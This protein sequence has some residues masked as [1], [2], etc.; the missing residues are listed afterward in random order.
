MVVAVSHTTREKR[1]KETDAVNYHFV[2]PGVFQRMI[3]EDAFLE[4][5]KV[6]DHLYGTSKVA[7]ERD[8]GVG[9]DV[10]LEIDWQGARQV[11]AALPQAVSIFILPP[12]LASLRSRLR[13]RGQ[14]DN[15]VIETR[16]AAARGEISHC[17]EYDYL[18]V[19][20]DFSIALGE[21]RAIT[22]AEHARHDHQR[23]RF[24]TLLDELMSTQ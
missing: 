17:D 9:R 21:V 20:D 2:A 3:K 15:A 5:A 22:H 12:S 19:N 24:K 14:D 1:P 7:V 18:V 11:R 23:G 8:L 13:S 16:L 6:F 4:Y 10:L